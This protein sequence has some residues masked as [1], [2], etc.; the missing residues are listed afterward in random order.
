M[1]EFSKL[2]GDVG[3]GIVSHFLD[4]FGWENHATNKYVSCHT[5]KHGKESHGIDALFA[6]NSPIESKTIEN[7]IV[8]SKYSSNPYSSVPST[9]KSH[10]EDI[11]MAIE[12][13]SKS[14]L[15]KDINDLVNFGSG[16]R[17]VETG[18]L[19]YI[20][21]DEDPDKQDIIDKVKN[22]Y[23]NSELKFRTI[24]LIDNK[25]ASFLYDSI[26]YIREKFGAENVN[27]FYPPTSLSLT[28][29]QK[30][31][32]GKILPVEYI[33][34]PILPFV[35]EKGSQEQPI[36]CLISSESFSEDALRCLISC[37]R[38]LVADITK[39]LLFVFEKYNAL[40]AKEIVDKVQLA[41]G[42][43]VFIEI[44]SYRSNFR[45]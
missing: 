21:N 36:V 33:S 38:D 11:A 14:Q 20:N 23:I 27:F 2:V 44:E 15:K 35:I 45:G 10:F 1:G 42:R 43:D 29:P 13:Y 32:F 41:V 3:E 22:S 18:V 39:N 25:R 6:Y 4:L 12:C 8:S 9:F 34:S 30:K 26:K 19:F 16:Y 28:N 24:H 40:N 7:I 31:Y 5:R 37:S 17:K